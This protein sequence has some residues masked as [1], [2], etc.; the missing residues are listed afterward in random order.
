MKNMTPRFGKRDT[1]SF[2]DLTYMNH[3]LTR[4]LVNLPR[5]MLRHMA[6]VISVPSHELPYGD[7]PTRRKHGVWWLGTGENRRR[8]DENEEVNNE[9]APAEN[10]EENPEGLDWVPVNNEADLQGEEIVREAEVRESGSGKKFYDAEDEIQG[11]ADVIVEV[12]EVPAFPASLADSTNVQTKGK[13]MTT[14][15]DPSGPSGSLPDSLLQHFQADLDRA[16]TERLQAE[17]DNARAENG[18]LQELL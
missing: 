9:N 16:H 7:W 15:V 13:T 10:V 12:P 11:P 1:T 3:F 4:R 18:K 2:M 6:Y 8:D 5:V 14:G 17:L